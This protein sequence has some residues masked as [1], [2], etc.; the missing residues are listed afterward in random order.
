MWNVNDHFGALPFIHF[1]LLYTDM[2]IYD[3]IEFDVT[4]SRYFNQYRSNDVH[5]GLWSTT[6]CYTRSYWC[7]YDT[8]VSDLVHLSLTRVTVAARVC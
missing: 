1:V 6:Y 4:S 8:Q 5:Y 2:M 7:L 3:M